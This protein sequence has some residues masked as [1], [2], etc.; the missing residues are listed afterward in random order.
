MLIA[1]T[2]AVKNRISFRTCS[3][4]FRLQASV[5]IFRLLE[6]LEFSVSSVMLSYW[7]INDRFV[8]SLLNIAI[9]LFEMVV[10]LFTEWKAAILPS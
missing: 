4:T 7:N 2:N 6:R 9:M 3:C 5:N 10:E 8:R 1:F